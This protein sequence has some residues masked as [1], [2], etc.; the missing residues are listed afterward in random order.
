L[1][2]GQQV[3][4]DKLEMLDNHIAN[5]RRKIMALSVTEQAALDQL[6]ADIDSVVAAIKDNQATLVQT[7]ADLTAT[8][9]DLQAQV[10]ADPQIIA[11]LTASRDAL[12][13]VV[14]SN[15]ADV[16]A[17]LSGLDAHVKTLGPSTP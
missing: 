13:A 9:A 10:G 2:A 16:V 6:A 15:D 14:D 12:Q 4:I 1:L 11:D 3:I 17:G 7:V 5:L 8:V